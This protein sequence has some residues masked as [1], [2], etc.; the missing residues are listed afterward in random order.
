MNGESPLSQ[1]ERELILAYAAI[2]AGCDFV[3]IAHAEVAYA[4]GIQR[5]LVEQL[6]D[7]PDEAAIDSKLKALLNFVRKL[8]TAP[9]NITQKD[10]HE[11]FLSGWSERA[12]HDAIAIT[13]RAAFM[14]RLVQGFGFTPPSVEVAAKHAQKRVQRGYVNLYSAFRKEPIIP[15]TT[16]PK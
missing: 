1:G 7:N 14:Q 10:T 6:R 13:A 15:D 12:L 16:Y 3:G 5:G 2:A 9:F 8:S 11:V 4:W